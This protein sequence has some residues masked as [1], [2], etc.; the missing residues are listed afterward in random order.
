[1]ANLNFEPIQRVEIKVNTQ[2][3]KLDYNGHVWHS[4]TGSVYELREDGKFEVQFI[5][6]ACR[7]YTLYGINDEFNYCNNF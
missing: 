7:T 3:I 5:S 1:M 4:A 6:G 2:L